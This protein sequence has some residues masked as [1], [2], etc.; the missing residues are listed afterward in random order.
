MESDETLYQENP[1]FLDGVP[2]SVRAFLERAA[3]ACEQRPKMLTAFE[4][5]LD[6]VESKP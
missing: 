3:R 1:G 2:S 6:T 5:M 4:T